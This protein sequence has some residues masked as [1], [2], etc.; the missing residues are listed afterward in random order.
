[1][2]EADIWKSYKL[3]DIASDDSILNT[4]RTQMSDLSKYITYLATTDSEF[5]YRLLHEALTGTIKFN[6]SPEAIPNYVLEW[7]MTDSNANNIY[8]IDEY[9]EHLKHRKVRYLISYKS[10]GSRKYVSLRIAVG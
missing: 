10:G 7:S 3:N 8:T 9:I 5:R 4:T 1:M 6:G 2:I